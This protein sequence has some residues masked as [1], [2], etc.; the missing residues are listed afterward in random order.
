MPKFLFRSALKACKSTDLG[1]CLHPRHGFSVRSPVKPYRNTLRAAAQPSSG[2]AKTTLISPPPPLSCFHTK[3]HPL[4]SSSAW[5]YAR[6]APRICQKGAG[7]LP[8]PLTC[9]AAPA[10]P[11]LFLA[12]PEEQ[13]QVRMSGL[14]GLPA[15]D[16]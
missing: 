14:I 10:A 13:E 16:R 5:F 1:G 11:L 3:Q 2:S 4:G 9:N 6:K 7:A 15:L 12:A 8:N